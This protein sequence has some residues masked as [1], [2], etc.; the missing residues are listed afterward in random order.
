MYCD[1]YPV[2]LFWGKSTP[3]KSLI[4][5]MV[6]VG[7]VTAALLKDGCFYQTG[8]FLSELLS[9]PN[10]EIV[11]TVSYLASLHDIGKCHPC[12]QNKNQEAKISVFLRDN[13]LLMNSGYANFGF[14]HEQ[15]SGRIIRR[16][17][18]DN[19]VVS[20]RT[21]RAI[22][23]VLSMHHQ[24]NDAGCF[25]VEEHNEK[26]WFEAQSRL[27]KIMYS[28]FQPSKIDIEICFHADAAFTL[29]LGI[30]I[31]ADWIASG[32][33]FSDLA[34]DD[35]PQH[36]Y[37]SSYKKARE[38]IETLGMVSYKS[39]PAYNMFTRLWKSIPAKSLR[40]IQNG[41]QDICNTE[42]PMLTII[43][44][45]MGEGK[46]EAGI[47]AAVCMGEKYNKGGMYIALPTAATSNQMY[48]RF[49]ELLANHQIG[50][51]KLLHSMAWV[52]DD[53]PIPNVDTEDADEAKQWFAPL[54]RGMLSNFAVGTVDQV[55]LSALKVKYG[56]LRLLGL[57]NK[58][59]IIDEIHAYDAYMSQIIKRLLQWCTALKVPVVLLSA[60]LPI[61][62]RQELI[63]ACGGAEIVSKG[64]PLITTVDC[65][66]K[67]REHNI[68][69]S[70]IKRR[71]KITVLPYLRRFDIVARLAV[72][73]VEGGGCL[74]V[75]VN[76]VTEA[77]DLYREIEKVA[78]QDL[79]LLLFHAR[80]VAEDRNHI[81]KQ[82]INL[83]G[84]NGDRPYK[85]ILVATQVAEQSLD[86]DFDAMI[87]AVAPVDL[88]LQRAGRIHRHEGRKRPDTLREPHL[89]VLMPEKSG[90]YGMTEAVYPPILLS[91]TLK[92]ING[93]DE[94]CIPEDI[95]ELVDDVYDMSP[96]E[97]EDIEGWADWQFEENLKKGAAREYEL[98]E[99]SERAFSMAESGSGFFEDNESSDSYLAAKTRL[100][101]PTA[102]VAFLPENENL[103]L[104]ESDMRNKDTARKVMARSISLRKKQLC[105]TP[106]IE[107][108]PPIE[109]KGLLKKV[110][111]FKL[112]GDRYDV[113]DEKIIGYRLDPKLGVIIERK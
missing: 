78:A 72:K 61:K 40:P 108:E 1:E 107:F 93:K 2:Y 79:Q 81:E 16:I 21:M 51:A 65:N 96:A 101:E 37:I 3:Y 25:E 20:K 12:F 73:M 33:W 27:E 56:V 52:F 109:G 74:C 95:R 105:T 111:I 49:S 63:Q 66:G 9:I 113:V 48:L 38:V 98:P 86:L 87:S 44:A 13:Q 31:L 36:Y 94:I 10:E 59:L 70:F 54:R 106:G 29:M 103:P 55:M 43:E 32:P 8:R 71:I 4:A 62:K 68:R 100:G 91:R 110:L 64:Y 7:C 26:W 42:Q 14:R 88:L 41:I 104:A 11:N 82:C 47:Y 112:R 102:L 50:S 34:M 35:D 24:R 18:S 30:V 67:A 57:S 6:D 15:Y 85:A 45:P 60:T 22:S 75:I 83:F 28:V 5:H 90:D 89:I 19:D 46:T 92:K 69:D 39:L 99:P 76:T 23:K 84:K 53:Q 58:V 17:F 80:F 77:Q 97:Q